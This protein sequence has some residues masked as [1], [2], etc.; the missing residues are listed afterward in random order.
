MAELKNEKPRAAG[1]YSVGYKKPPVE[2]QFKP[3]YLRDSAEQNKSRRKETLPDLAGMMEKPLQVKRG[4]KTV[5]MHP[6][7]AEITSLGNRALKGEPR[8]AKLFLQHCDAA[9]LFNPPPGEQTHGVFVIPKELNYTIA[10]FLLKT[11]GL[12]PWDPDLY[13]ALLAEP[14]RDSKE[15]YIE[16]MKGLENE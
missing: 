6:F 2:H 3:G 5:A 12:P 15:V 14:K 13:A 8:A 1:N 7:E 10:S 9:G 4:G 16:F 11:Q